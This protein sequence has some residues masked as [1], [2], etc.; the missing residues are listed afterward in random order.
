MDSDNQYDPNDIFK[1]YKNL[2]NQ[3]LDLIRW[4]EILYAR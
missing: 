2:Q 4:K 1:L 3:G